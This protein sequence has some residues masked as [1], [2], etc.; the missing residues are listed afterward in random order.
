MTIHLKRNCKLFSQ[1]RPSNDDGAMQLR[2]DH[3]QISSK[4]RK[5]NDPKSRKQKYALA[6]QEKEETSLRESERDTMDIEPENE[7]SSGDINK[8]R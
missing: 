4:K 3:K 7:H 5:T 2:E 1:T 6:E 8:E